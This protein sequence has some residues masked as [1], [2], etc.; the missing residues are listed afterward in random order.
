[1]R[2]RFHSLLAG[3]A[4]EWERTVL[5]GM[6]VVLTLVLAPGLLSF[7]QFFRSPRVVRQRRPQARTIDLPTLSCPTNLDASDVFRPPF[8]KKQDDKRGKPG[9]ADD[10]T[11][12]EDNGSDGDDGKDD[13]EDIEFPP[14]PIV[15][16]YYNGFLKSGS[17]E[18]RAFLTVTV[19][20]KG[21]MVPLEEG[22]WAQGYCVVLFDRE[23]AMLITPSGQAMT[24]SQGETIWQR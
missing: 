17:G 22:D 5:M 21:T 2:R 1:M 19:D 12:E 9:G 20:G 14:S 24:I 3:M 11:I 16:L 4:R 18:E 7:R 13:R 8:E 10:V 23:Q 15:A 6:I